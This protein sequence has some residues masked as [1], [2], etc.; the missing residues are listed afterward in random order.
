MKISMTLQ[1]E[2]SSDYAL[3]KTASALMIPQI[4]VVREGMFLPWAAF[5]MEHIPLLL[6][7][8]DE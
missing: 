3:S 6:R 1:R 8:V 2:S 5:R 4:G 7:P